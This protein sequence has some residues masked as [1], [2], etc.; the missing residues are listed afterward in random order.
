MMSD[1][2]STNDSESESYA[3]ATS[4]FVVDQ[5]HTCE[6]MLNER[7]RLQLGPRASALRVVDGGVATGKRACACIVAAH[8]GSIRL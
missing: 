5:F 7:G 4:K 6:D 8:F 1:T 3:A 2:M